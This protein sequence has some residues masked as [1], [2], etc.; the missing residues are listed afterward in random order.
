VAFF[1]KSNT[2]SLFKRIFLKR[3]KK[4]LIK[5]LRSLKKT[6]FRRLSRAVVGKDKVDAEVLDDLE[7]V[8]IGADVGI[9]TTIKIIQR[10]EERVLE[11]ST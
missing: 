8:L 10:I 1:V 5:G 7:E 9:D 6:C 4:P 2:M 11:T 3:T